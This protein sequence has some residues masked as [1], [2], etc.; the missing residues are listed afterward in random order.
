M[1][2]KRAPLGYRILRVSRILR[3]NPPAGW[4]P[5]LLVVQ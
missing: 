5:V 4:L 1:R 3:V 2:R